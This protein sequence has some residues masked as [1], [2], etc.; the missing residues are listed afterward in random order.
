[1]LQTALDLLE[2]DYAVHVP[3]DAVCSRAQGNYKQGLRF[4]ERAGAIV[5]STETVAFQLLARAGTPEFK[6]IAA[7][8]K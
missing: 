5:S 7:L 3:W 2:Q 8:L 1:M 6:E 4:M